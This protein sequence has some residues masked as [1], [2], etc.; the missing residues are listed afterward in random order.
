MTWCHATSRLNL[1]RNR[2]GRRDMS[3]HKGQVVGYVRVSTLAGDWRDKSTSHI[4]LGST[5]TYEL[6]VSRPPSSKPISLRKR[7]S[8]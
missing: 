2:Q 4:A 7:F 5:I 8:E 1:T 3:K 6:V